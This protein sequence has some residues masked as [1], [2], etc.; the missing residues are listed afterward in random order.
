MKYKVYIKGCLL[1]LACVLTG[2]IENDIPYPVVKAEI[3]EI[4]TNGFVSSSIDKAARSAS[5]LVDDTV[6]LRTLRITKF[7]VTEGT[8]IVPDSIACKDAS[9]FPDSGFV[10]VDSLPATVNTEINLLSPATFVL[11]TYQ[12]YPWQISAKRN[13][14][15]KFSLKAA[16]G[17]D[18]QV[19]TPIVDE[20]NRKVIIYV[21]KDTD[22]GNLKVQE[23]RLGSSIAKTVP[24]PETI[25][26][27][28][29]ART[30]EV[31]AFDVTEIWSVSVVHYEGTGASLSVWAKR[32][33]LTGVAKEGTTIDIQYRQ[34]GEEIW[35]QVF[36]DEITFNED[37]TFSAAMRH[38]VPATEY[39]YK[40]TIG[41]QTYDVTGFTTDVAAQLPNSGFEDWWMNTK[42]IWFVYAEGDEKFWDTGN[43]GSALANKN[44]TVYDDSKPHGGKRSIKLA[45]ENVI[46]KFA[47]G[48]LF[49]GEYV[50]TDGT[51]G[52]LDFGRPFTARP[53]TLKGWFKYAC[54]PITHISDDQEDRFEDAQKGM[55]DKAHIYIALGDWTAPVRIQTKKAKR[56]L[57]DKNDQHIIAY[58][59]MIV[60]KTVGDWTEFKLKLD[61]RSLTRKPTYIVVVAS[62][63][64]Y[65]DYFTGGD[66]S[67]LWLDDFELIYE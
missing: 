53:T 58:Q 40:A 51:D 3:Q 1:S 14:Q 64:K 55:N 6:D 52:I 60:D 61:Y 59:E 48:N 23:M 21:S 16:D 45:S 33:Y 62:A 13:I 25:T 66:G 10:S 35:D 49:A 57:F 9:L 17:S 20:E 8:T 56:Q 26:D 19:G 7:L 41:T 47:A 15:R 67:T 32:A 5:I 28:R 27:F 36:D 12:E 43:T 4:E 24:L 18:V 65:G 31:T 29:R 46:I 30:F 39:E 38:L 50:K 2:C 34:K 42:N 54:K 37:G 22:L 11:R 63:S 44:V